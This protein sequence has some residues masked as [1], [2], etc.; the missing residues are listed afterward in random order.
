MLGI[1]SSKFPLSH[2]LDAF[3]SECPIAL[4]EVNQTRHIIQANAAFCDLLHVSDP[5]YKQKTIL[6]FLDE[7]DRGRFTEALTQAKTAKSAKGNLPF[8][9]HTPD[10]QEVNVSLHVT[11]IPAQGRQSEKLYVFLV[12]IT[13]QKNLELR[14]VHSRK[15]RRWDNWQGAWRMISTTC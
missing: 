4:A 1:F 11:L 14:F 10:R 12:D 13:D 6:E 8:T 7:N 15:C 5:E 9:L 3:V 2:L